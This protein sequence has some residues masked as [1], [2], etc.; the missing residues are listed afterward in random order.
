MQTNCGDE[1]ELDLDIPVLSVERSK[2]LFQSISVPQAGPTLEEVPFEPLQIFEL[3]TEQSMDDNCKAMVSKSSAMED[4]RVMLVRDS[5]LDG[6]RQVVIPENLQS[7]CLAL[8]PLPKISGHTGST[9]L[10]AQKRRVVYWSRMA[11]DVSKYVASC[12]SCAKKS[13]RTGRKTTKISYFPHLRPW[14]SWL[15]TYSG[16][17]LP[18][19]E[20]TNSY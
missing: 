11:V 14:S 20:V 10:Y 18:L 1:N 3:I 19:I 5:P 9:T 12:P 6:A 15:W 17:S 4:E 8:F 7:R 2:P 16:L 13:L